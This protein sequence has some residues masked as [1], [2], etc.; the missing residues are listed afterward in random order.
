MTLALN[1]TTATD[2]YLNGTKID[3]AYLNGTEVYSSYTPTHTLTVG[4]NYV[5]GSNWYG[6]DTGFSGTY[7]SLSPSTIGGNAVSVLS[8][9]TPL[10]YIVLRVS[11]P[12]VTLTIP[13]GSSC[14]IPTYV[15]Y[16][17][18]AEFITYFSSNNG[19]AVPIRLTV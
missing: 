2:I 7:G 14:V 13:S 19:N 12:A 3:K 9:R 11:G 15:D 8:V 1:G 6:F 4:T 17:P 16:D 10:N 5:G 18:P